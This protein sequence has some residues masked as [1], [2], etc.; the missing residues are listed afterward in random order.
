M[1]PAQDTRNKSPLRTMVTN[2]LKKPNI[3]LTCTFTAW[4]QLHK[5]LY[6]LFTIATFL[7][8]TISIEKHCA[9]HIFHS[10]QQ[11]LALLP[12][13]RFLFTIFFTT[14]N[15]VGSTTVFN[16]VTANSIKVVLPKASTVNY[17]RARDDGLLLIFTPKLGIVSLKH[18]RDHIG[19]LRRQIY[20][21]ER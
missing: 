19:N 17:E 21:L 11:M 13:F 8:I 5:T 6:C 20:L 9:T 12:Q 15:N 3:F 16:S 4:G 18:L 7:K 10:D 14:V 2:T 1:E